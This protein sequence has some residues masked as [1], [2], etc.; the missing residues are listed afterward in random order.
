M[1]PCRPE[2]KAQ[3][4]ETRFRFSVFSRPTFDMNTELTKAV[5]LVLAAMA[6]AGTASAQDST[7]LLNSMP[8]D[9][10][11]PTSTTEQVNDYVVDV[12][13]FK[14]SDGR[15]YGIAPVS[16]A[17]QDF[18]FPN[19]FT[20][21]MSAQSIS[22]RTKTGVPFVR[23]SYSSWNAA[24]SGVN[25]DATR[26]NP[27]VPINT[28]ALAGNQF[29]Y[30]FSQFSSDDP[31]SPS[32][33]FNSIVGGV[34]NYENDLPSRLYVSR[35]MGATND[36]NW[37]CNVAQFGIG[38]VDADGWMTVRAD[39]FGSSDCGGKL[40]FTGNNYF[41]IDL[42]S[43]NAGV[44]NILSK[45]GAADT[46]IHALVESATTHSPASMI[47]S[48]VTGGT[49]VLLGSNFSAQFV[50]GSGPMTSTTAQQAVGVTDQRG[51]VSYCEQDFT[52]IFGAGST[53]GSAVILGK[54]AGTTALMA[55]GLAASGAP[56]NP[57]ALHYPGNASISDPETG[58]APAAGTASF[59][60]YYS[61]TPFRGGTGQVA[62]GMDQSGRMLAAAQMH[63]PDFVVSTHYNNMIVV[64]RTSNGV[65]SE[66]VVA[67]YTNGN[68]GK[69]VHGSFGSTVVG[70][71]VAHEAGATLPS[72]PSLTSPMIDSVGNLYF[73]GRV[74][75]TGET[76]YRDSLVRAIY[77]ASAFE[78]RLE[79]VLTEGD[80]FKGANSTK[81]YQVNFLQTSGNG[82]STPSAPYSQ[83]INQHAYNGL[84]PASLDS[85]STK[86]LGGI[87]LAATIV[88]DI[89]DDGIFE[90]QSVNPASPDQ[91]YQTLLYITSAEDCND[92][93]VP[94]DL[95]I[96]NGTSTDSDSDGVPDECGA[97]SSFCF[98]GGGACPC[99]NDAGPAEGCRHSQG[100][101]A[102][103]FTSGSASITA[104]DLGFDASQLPTGKP[105]LLFS[106]DLQVNLLFGDGIRC[107]GGDIKRLGVRI[108]N[109][110]GLASWAPSLQSVGGWG[111]GDTR[112]FQVWFRDPVG[113]PCA[114]GFNVSSAVQVDFIP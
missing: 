83:N 63:H 98:G 29:G 103:V 78:Y 15:V 55:W 19:F 74:Q 84:N 95:D 24:G 87:V 105:C 31:A 76:F 102:V 35:V 33:N 5:P 96:D 67:A 107:V 7:S 27:G 93:G 66:W 9:S 61:S 53:S 104:D 1:T 88:Y 20:A 28:S 82:G 54:P 42:L 44:V 113:G 56:I 57:I 6:L 41:L 75:L 32:I 3:L 100:Q 4:P 106:G 39:G 47:P 71:L 92:N 21:S 91:D 48:F 43:R 58:W 51:L 13:A 12:T 108:S 80:V 65:A 36:G 26:N 109:G 30:S 68:D 99:G 16:K 70:K 59:A 45:T 60:N 81:N 17:S 11:D 101:G 37:Q 62:L 97:G 85:T 2:T 72:G 8:G 77:N 79:L 23:S 64:A 114:S 10:L 94:D 69:P 52:G 110:S 112:Y 14:S 22:R 73:N 86:T 49:P 38:A 40:A 46:G 50:Y 90:R 25:G 18:L 34:V 111:N 89:N